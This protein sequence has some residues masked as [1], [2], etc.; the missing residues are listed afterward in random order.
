MYT[1]YEQTILDNIDFDGYG[2]TVT[3]NYS[4][5]KEVYSIFKKEY[6]HMIE[7]VGERKAFAEWLQGLPS[8]LSV[9]FYYDEIIANAFSAGINIE[10]E[11]KLCADYWIK[12]SDAFFTL[13]DNL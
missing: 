9:P 4:K 5:V 2:I 6:G 11:E 3:D 8:T 10:D 12:L 13:K 1:H 7:R